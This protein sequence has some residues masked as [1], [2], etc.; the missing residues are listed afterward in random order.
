MTMVIYAVNSMIELSVFQ[1]VMIFLSF[2][3]LAWLL[4][5]CFVHS[6]R[7]FRGCSFRRLV[8]GFRE[9]MWMT[10]GLG[11][12]FF[13]LYFVL[14]YYGTRLVNSSKKLDLFFLAYK[15]PVPFIYLG[16]GIFA[17]LSLSIYAVRVII[18]KF[19]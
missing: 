18:K 2:I 11:V 4:V 9:K 6:G 17:M 13:G 8:Y 10:I 7:I 14:I 15:N 5:Y 3:L 1:L 12:T 19:S 16:L